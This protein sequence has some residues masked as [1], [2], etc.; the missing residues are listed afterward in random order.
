MPDQERVLN[1][2]L[3][4]EHHGYL[5][6]LAAAASFG[7]MSFF[8]HQNPYQYP[9]EQLVFFRGL[10]GTILLLPLVWKKIYLFFRRDGK[11]L[12]L[13]SFAGAVSILCFFYTLQNTSP[14]NANLLASSTPIFVGIF[15]WIFFSEKL[16]SREMIGILLVLL[17]DVLLHIPSQSSIPF[18]VGAIGLF[19]ALTTSI[20]FMSLRQVAQKYSASLIVFGFSLISLLISYFWHGSHIWIMPRSNH[21]IFL[22]AVAFLGLFSQILTTLAFTYVRGSVAAAI[23]RSVIIW[24]GIFDFFWGSFKPSNIELISYTAVLLGVF[25]VQNRSAKNNAAQVNKKNN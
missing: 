25:L 10:S 20:A 22:L 2:R 18:T 23:G 24:S 7:L 6:A 16:N 9:G 11:L 8:A 1:K 4:K 12:W 15:S 17:G 3:S 14:A 5:F 19:G 13:R 21:I